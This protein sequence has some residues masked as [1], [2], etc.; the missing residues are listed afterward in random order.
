MAYHVQPLTYKMGCKSSM[1]FVKPEL[2]LMLTVL[3]QN[4]LLMA[5]FLVDYLAV[6]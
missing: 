6:S 2:K 4:P 1:I 5:V 3:A